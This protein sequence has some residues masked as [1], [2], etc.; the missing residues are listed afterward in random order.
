[1][2]IT[3]V[4]SLFPHLGPS[5]WWQ[6]GVP[7]PASD[8]ATRHHRSGL[9]AGV[10]SQLPGAK[11]GPLRTF[12][13]ELGGSRVPHH[14]CG[15]SGHP[16]AHQAVQRVR[17]CEDS[18]A[19]RALVQTRPHPELLAVSRWLR[20]RGSGPRPGSSGGGGRDRLRPA[21]TQRSADRQDGAGNHAA[22]QRGDH[23]ERRTS[24][25]RPSRRASRRRT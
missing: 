17:L 19:L 6:F 22:R 20:R 15:V 10:L 4:T 7:D 2:R 5:V 23:G 8:E 1:M 16:A 25:A 9:P 13:P 12:R 3:V 24:P 21:E 14:L 11:A 18:A